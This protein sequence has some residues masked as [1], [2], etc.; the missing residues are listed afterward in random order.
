MPTPKGVCVEGG[1]NL[2]FGQI[3]IVKKV[4]FPKTNDDKKV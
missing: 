1:S 2:L 3:L 4:I